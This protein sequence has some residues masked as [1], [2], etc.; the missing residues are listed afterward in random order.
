M[1]GTAKRPNIVLV[2]ADQWRAQAA[3]Y[4][5]DPNIKT[6]NL[7]SLAGRCVNFTHAV[8]GCPVCSPYRASLIT[9][10]YP[11][12]HGVI[13]NDVCLNDDAVSLARAFK[14]AGYDTG[15]IGKW[16]L[17]GH[18]RRSYIPPERRQG[19]E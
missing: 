15:Y 5:G 9:G 3:G 18:G 10:R 7:D 19:F 17:D 1:S 6:P 13:V 2:L 11:L 16:H 8:S 12:T 14:G 4:A